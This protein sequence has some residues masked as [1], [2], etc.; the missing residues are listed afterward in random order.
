MK[1][2]RSCIKKVRLSIFSFHS[3][4]M[5]SKLLILG[6]AFLTL[7]G[8]GQAQNKPVLDKIVAVVGNEIILKSELDY[9]VQLLAY[10]NKLDAN[11]PSLR[12]RVLEGLVDDKLI[13]AQAILDSVTVADDEVNREL[14]S[15]IQNLIKQLGSQEKVEEVYGMSINKIRSEF[16]DEMRK[17]LIIQKLKQQK[18]GDMKVSSVDVRDFYGTYKDSIPEIPEQVTLSHIFMVPKQSEKARADA[19]SEAKAILDSLRNGADFAEFAKKYSQDPGS[20]SSG[21][22]LGWANRGQFVLE[23][24]HAVYA[25]KPGEISDIVETQFGLHIIQ[26]VERRGDLVHARH[27]LIKIPHLKSDDDSVKVFLDSLRARAMRGESFATLASEY[28][29]DQDTREIGGD[30]GTV[31]LDQLKDNPAFLDTVR[32]MKI[33]EISEPIK[34]I[35]GKSYGYNIVYLRNRI[36]AHKVNVDQDYDRLSNMALSMKQNDAYLKWI[37]QLKKQIYCKILS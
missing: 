16:R 17:Q 11:D 36:P 37:D 24:E 30:L 35:F 10:Q 20:A 23:F 28:S 1:L 9:Q 31:T 22:D 27:I 15:R 13:L 12:S 26:L 18:F 14:D 8:T 6:F 4:I 25:L 5:N 34:V 29:Q 33:G 7:A 19:Y 32:N 2:I 3:L 21:G